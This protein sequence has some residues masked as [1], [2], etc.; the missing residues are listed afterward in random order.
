[1]KKLKTAIIGCGYWGPNI[2][3]NVYGNSKV[4]EI[5]CVDLDQTKLDKI[6]SR[7]PG[8]NTHSDF[9]GLLERH[10]I[11]CFF[12]AT[13]ISTHFNIAKKV[14]SSGK[15]VFIEK[16]LAGTV[17]EGK[18]LV[19]LAEERNVRLMVGHTFE[20]SPAVIKIKNMI[21]QGVLGEIYYIFTTR[22]NLGL[23]QKDVSV[24][25]DL[26]PHDFSI[27]FSLLQ[28][29][30]TEVSAFGRD[31]VK[32]GLPDIAFLNLK[33]KSGVVCN[34]TVSW[35][36]PTKLRKTVIAGKEKMLVYDDTESYEKIKVFDKGVDFKDPETFG[37]YQLSYR[38][39]D[40]WSP[41]LDS[42]EPLAEE[43]NHFFSCIS[44]GENPITDGRNGLRVLRAL[45]AADISINNSGKFISVTNNG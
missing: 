26:C 29:E 39:G 27:I 1:M 15:H 7:Y 44:N 38:S 24:I 3:R 18:E 37:E 4:G 12:V 28:E 31:C 16:P 43:I 6:K 11:D 42:F 20:F 35:L 25:W 22:V 34:I 17:E 10:D 45:E 23:H 30:P 36:A 9:A 32:S 40:I 13:P 21:S 33:F 14:I 41:R 19:R 2:V 5:H 8:I